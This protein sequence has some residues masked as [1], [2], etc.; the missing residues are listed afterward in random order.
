MGPYQMEDHIW[1]PD[2]DVFLGWAPEMLWAESAPLDSTEPEQYQPQFW[3]I[4]RHP[5]FKSGNKRLDQV[6]WLSWEM[7]GPQHHTLLS[8]YNIVEMTFFSRMSFI[9]NYH[10]PKR[11]QARCDNYL[12]VI[13]SCIDSF[14]I[15]L[16]LC[17]KSYTR[18][19][20]KFQVCVSPVPFPLSICV[21]PHRIQ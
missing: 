21:Y 15:I 2:L 14:H 16:L 10:T 6:I 7:I 3:C 12:S 8:K 9:N 19:Q 5:W 1:L 4:I 13:H 18:T 20:K 17:R 11:T